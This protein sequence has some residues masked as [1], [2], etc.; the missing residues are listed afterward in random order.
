MRLISWIL[1]GLVAGVLAKWSM[2]GAAFGG[3]IARLLGRTG[4]T[5][6]DAWSIL[7]AALGAILFLLAYDLIVRRSA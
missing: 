1:V 2:G 4:A 3:F 5:G 7:V 6:F